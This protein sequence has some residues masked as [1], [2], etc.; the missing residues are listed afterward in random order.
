M[1]ARGWD[2]RLSLPGLIVD[3][4][5]VVDEVVRMWGRMAASQ[6]TCP[7]CGTASRSYHSR[8]DR[9]LSDLPISG[10]KVQLRL[11]VRRFRCVHA[12]C[13]RRTFSEP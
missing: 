11:S 4:R 6:A 2:E 5:A 1:G 7:D 3:Q 12:P 9:T 10:S 13:T 8:Y